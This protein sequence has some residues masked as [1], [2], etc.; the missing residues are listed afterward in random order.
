[1]TYAIILIVAGLILVLLEILIPSGGLISVLAATVIIGG[2]VLGF[3][4]SSVTGTVLLIATFICIPL[5]IT[6]GLKF[7][8]QTAIGRRMFLIPTHKQA[9]A[10]LDAPAGVSDVDYSHLRGKIGQTVTPLRPSGIAEI[11]GRRYSV[12]AL[13]ELIDKDVQVIVV[14]VQG[15]SIV[16]DDRIV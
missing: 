16:V 1:M 13:G 11:E 12:V 15:N 9:T 14:K 8:P 10:G 4:H 7:F 2:L 3:Q 5:F 6:L